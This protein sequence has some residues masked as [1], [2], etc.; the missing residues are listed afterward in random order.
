MSGVLWC[1]QDLGLS[2]LLLVFS[3]ISTVASRLLH[4][5]STIDKISRLKMK[6]FSTVSDTQRGTQLHEKEKRVEGDRGDQ[7]EKRGNQ[8][9]REQ[10]SQ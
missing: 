7:E 6:S 5:Y 3:L 8:K 1:S 4:V 9:G 10:A 2:L